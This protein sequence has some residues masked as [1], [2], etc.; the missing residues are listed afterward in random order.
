[1]F[2]ANGEASDHKVVSTT[3]TCA[4]LW[5]VGFMFMTSIPE[6]SE[7]LSPWQFTVTTVTGTLFF[8]EFLGRIFSINTTQDQ[9][10]VSA[11]TMRMKYIKSFMGIVD[12]IAI[13]PLC[14]VLINIHSVA[15]FDIVTSI[16]LFKMGRY[17][18]GIEMVGAVIV[19]EKRPLI[20]AISSLGMLMIVMATVM[21]LFENTAQPLIF[22]SIPHTLWW[23][24]V[25]MT[26]VGYGDIVPMTLGG[27]IFGSLSMLTSVGMLA[28]PTAIIANGYSQ[29]LKRREILENWQMV[30]NFPLFK[31]LDGS[32]IAVIASML[33]PQIMPAQSVVVTKG[34]F[35]DS[36]YFIVEGQVEVVVSPKHIILKSGDFFGEMGLIENKPRSAT[37]YTLSTTR[38]LVLGISEFH[39][40]M[41]KQP[42]IREKILMVS[43]SR[44]MKDST[45]SKESTHA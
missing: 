1:M 5:S 39:D 34:Q 37:I 2:Y 18:P 45:P 16:A 7:E 27:K 3:V 31:E 24:M 36:M 6:L 44:K 29:E 28:I 8:F 17:V 4:I 10:G 38:F 12:L 21:Y 14:V 22:K 15:L 33:K 35:S 20:A 9:T 42:E 25:T 23:G 19:M 30:S 13:L 26:T 43:Q 11:R 32:H 41:D 40:L